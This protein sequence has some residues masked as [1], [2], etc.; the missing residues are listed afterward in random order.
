M[1]DIISRGVG[2]LK[3]S[4]FGDDA[5][6]AKALPWQPEQVWSILKQ[7]TKNDEVC[8]SRGTIYYQN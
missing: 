7:L 4:A 8:L 6:D 3:K 2:E 5:E 1:Q